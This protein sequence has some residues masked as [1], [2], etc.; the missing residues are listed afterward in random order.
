MG[1]RSERVLDELAELFL[2]GTDVLEDLAVRGIGIAAGVTAAPVSSRAARAVVML[3]TKG[4]G[5]A[6]CGR[7]RRA[8][9]PG[10]HAG[11]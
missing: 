4:C 6:R 2:L 1:Q 3:I 9:G 5:G 8:R 7:S 10:Q 11:R